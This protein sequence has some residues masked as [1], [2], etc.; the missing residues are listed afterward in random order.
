MSDYRKRPG[1][2]SPPGGSPPRH[3]NGPASRRFDSEPPRDASAD[4]T[5]DPEGT[6]AA[7]GVGAVHREWA[8]LRLV[9]EIGRGGFGCVYRA[10]DTALAREVA[11]KLV[12]VPEVDLEASSLVLEEGRMLA[13][14]RHPNVVTVH[15]ALQVGQEVGLW[16]ELVRGRSLAD[17]VKADGPRGPEEAAVIV[18][19]VCRALAAVH[20]AGLVHRDVKAHNVMRES[21]GRIVL[22]DFGAGRDAALPEAGWSRAPGTPSYMAPEVIAGEPATRSSDI[23]SVGVLLYFLVTGRYPFEGRTLMEIAVGHGTGRRR[24]LADER[25]DLP[26]PFIRLV[27]RALATNP[28]ERFASA[29]ALIHELSDVLPAV[30]RENRSMER[31]NAQVA[32][33]QVSSAVEDNRSSGTRAGTAEAAIPWWLQPSA[34]KV[35]GIAGL[36]AWGIPFVLGFLGSVA[37]NHT[38]GRPASFDDEPV[39]AWWVWGLRTLVAPITYIAASAL[40][41]GVLLSAW[42]IAR[43]LYQPLDHWHRRTA[44]ALRASLRQRHLDDP[45]MI[46]QLVLVGEVLAALAIVLHF[47]QLVMAQFTFIDTTPARHLAALSPQNVMEHV[48]YGWALDG[49]VFLA[50]AAWLTLI[51]TRV[52]SGLPPANG[53]VMAGLA[54][55]VM[56]TLVM[57]TLPYRITWHNQ[58]ER[59]EYAGERCYLIGQR[60]GELLLYCADRDPPRN[61]TIS[62]ADPQLS[63]SGV[64]ESIFTPPDGVERPAVRQRR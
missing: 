10:W 23:Y 17:V 22:M 12:R 1:P 27:E 52:R 25:P 5:S 47:R 33:V 37:F 62:G 63:R 4:V 31:G 60:E 38:L 21:G 7:P 59:V 2:S 6:A 49:L 19:S 54:L 53:H 14:V 13:R 48:R 29:G 30:M 61:R 56:S 50:G 44:E 55:M 42:R 34:L 8:H 35:A 40:A 51:R 26:D 18:L 11:L 57:W 3:D 46:G 36:A 24:L 43:H 39:I 9:E 20:A 41:L 64:I 32:S 28:A 45:D 16:M 15:G 58:F